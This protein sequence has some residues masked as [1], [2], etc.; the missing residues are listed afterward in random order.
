MDNDKAYRL[1]KIAEYRVDFDPFFRY[2]P[3]LEERKGK[4]Q[5]RLYDGGD[6][7]HSVSIPVYDGTLLNFVKGM[8]ATG[9]MD[10]NYPYI[11]SNR[12]MITAED[13]LYQISQA[14]LKD[15]EVILGI[16]SKYVLGGMTRGKLWTDAVEN[17]LFYH[18][19]V[20]IKEILEV[21]DEP[22]V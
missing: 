3:W 12:N 1:Q 22:L 10:R 9:L 5:S 6:I 21:W 17:G 11:Y 20:R 4:R 19:L 15:M 7:S 8:Q 2:I 18:A 13:E 16:L 14:G